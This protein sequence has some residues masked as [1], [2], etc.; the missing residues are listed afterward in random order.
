MQVKAHYQVAAWA[1]I[2]NFAGKLEHSPHQKIGNVRKCWHRNIFGNPIVRAVSERRYLKM[3]TYQ[4]LPWS[5][6]FGF[7]HWP[8]GISHFFRETVSIWPPTPSG[9]DNVLRKW[10]SRF[11]WTS[12]E[13]FWTLP[14]PLVNTRA[15]SRFDRQYQGRIGNGKAL[16]NR[17]PFRFLLRTSQVG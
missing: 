9:L 12:C 15:V 8:Q 6:R 3:N 14:S 7:C 10:A 11:L 5:N 1:I 4:T 17:T 2:W 16:L 13:H